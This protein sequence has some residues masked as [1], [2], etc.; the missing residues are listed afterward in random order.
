MSLF[1]RNSWTKN[2]WYTEIRFQ[3]FNTRRPRVP[4]LLT[5]PAKNSAHTCMSPTVCLSVCH[6]C[7][8]RGLRS[9]QA[10]VRS[11]VLC[12]SKL[13][14]ILTATIPMSSFQYWTNK[15]KNEWLDSCKFPILKSNDKDYILSN[16]NLF[17]S[18]AIKYSNSNLWNNPN[19]D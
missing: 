4:L 5:V 7:G 16:V 2:P 10:T 18:D 14:G 8:Q 17:V 15:C 6:T 9:G 19:C 11:H 13:W 3:V 1:H 12:T